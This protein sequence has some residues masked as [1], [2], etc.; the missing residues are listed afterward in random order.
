MILKDPFWTEGQGSKMPNSTLALAYSQN[1]IPAI[2]SGFRSFLTSTYYLTPLS[3]FVTYKLFWW[4][5]FIQKYDNYSLGYST[6]F[7]S[8]CKFAPF[9][10][11]S[12]TLPKHKYGHTQ[13]FLTFNIY[14]YG[15]LLQN[16]MVL[17]GCVQ[18]FMAISGWSFAMKNP[19]LLVKTLKNRICY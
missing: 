16:F 19:N 9:S 15:T 13:N 3:I 7:R 11:F 14:I 12:S 5:I 2:H 10:I 17:G 1:Q 8:W 4:T 6:L 18:Q